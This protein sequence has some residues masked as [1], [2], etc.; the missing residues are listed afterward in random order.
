MQTRKRTS[1][2]QRGIDGRTL[3][4]HALAITTGPH[5]TE[6]PALV[7][8]LFQ[9]VDP[10]QLN[11]AMPPVKHFGE[12]MAQPYRKMGL[13]AL[14][15]AQGF[16]GRVDGL[17]DTLATVL[18]IH[19]IKVLAAEIFFVAPYPIMAPLNWLIQLSSHAIPCRAT[20]TVA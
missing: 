19:I 5:D 17:D 4:H 18:L 13:Q 3:A 12:V 10:R 7:D 8:A 2:G 11:R 1:A 9:P 14:A 20:Q 15:P 6:A 16:D